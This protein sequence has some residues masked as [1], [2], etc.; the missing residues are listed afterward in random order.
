VN[1]SFP[2]AIRNRNPE[3]DMHAE[4]RENFRTWFSDIGYLYIIVIVAIA[5]LFLFKDL[6]IDPAS[7]RKIVDDA[8]TTEPF[9]DR[10]P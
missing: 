2:S 9:Y 10:N 5:L 6:R 7:S 8:A 4:R 1:L 3:T